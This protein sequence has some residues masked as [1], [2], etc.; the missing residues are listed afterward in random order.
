MAIG[1]LI[2]EVMKDVRGAWVELVGRVKGKL[3]GEILRQMRREMSRE[4]SRNY[5]VNE[6]VREMVQGRSEA[7]KLF[8]DISSSY[9]RRLSILE[10]FWGLREDR[11]YGCVRQGLATAFLV[12]YTKLKTAVNFYTAT[13]LTD[14]EGPL[15]SLLRVYIQLLRTFLPWASIGLFHQSNRQAYND[16]DVKITYAMFC[17]TAVLELYSSLCL[18]LTGETGEEW[19]EMVAQYSFI[20]YFARNRKH[21]NKMWVVSLLGCKDFLD[22]H[23]CMKSC[24]SSARISELVLRY[25]KDG[26]RKKIEDAASYRRF[27]DHRS[28]KGLSLSTNRNRPLLFDESVLL[29]HIA[30]EFCFF[31]SSL[32]EHRCAFAKV[33]TWT[34]RLPDPSLFVQGNRRLPAP[35]SHSLQGKLQLIIGGIIER[36]IEMVPIPTSLPVKNG[37]TTSQCGQEFTSCKAVLC[38]QMCN[39]MAYLLLVNPE[40]LLPGS[41]RNLFTAAHQELEAIF[42]DD[43]QPLTLDNKTELTQKI[44]SKLNSSSEQ[45]ATSGTFIHEAW[46]LAQKLQSSG[47]EKKMWED[48]QDVW[49]EMLCFSAGRCRGYLHAKALGKG[50]EF[51]SYVWLLLFHMGMETFTDK[52]QRE[53]KEHDAANHAATAPPSTSE[54]VSSATTGAGTAPSTSSDVHS[55]SAAPSTSEIR[56]AEDDD[57][58]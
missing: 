58:V 40:M 17:C 50:G 56:M 14:Y 26:W 5:Q 7:S 22:Q 28:N 25:L 24:F 18:V 33:P 41:R 45:A 15:K 43:N 42:K 9:P 48:I 54:Q 1:T 6:R 11:A 34:K 23:W 55:A 16:I 27:N 35:D 39:Y 46:M 29:W 13:D 57:M 8:V 36:I 20:G 3:V 53:V 37:Q 31:S 44:I 19:P 21:S 12:L 30:T 32:S 10:D 52:L 2:G 38:T 51:L 47:D 4:R 49:V